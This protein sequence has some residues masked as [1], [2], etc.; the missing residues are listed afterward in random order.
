MTRLLLKTPSGSRILNLLFVAAT[1][2]LAS[3]SANAQ[4]RR[5]AAQTPASREDPSSSFNE[6]RGIQLGML[7]DD[8]RKKL[9]SPKDKGDEQDFYIFNDETE[10]AQIVYDKTHKVITISADFL[11]STEALTAKQVLGAEVEAKADGSVYKL[12]RYPKAGYWL[13][14]NRTSGAAPLTTITLQKIQ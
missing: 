5:A 3:S 9:G 1:L 10:M 8:V 14:Y 12:V 6:Y 13:S 7:A 11:K 4:V 2:L